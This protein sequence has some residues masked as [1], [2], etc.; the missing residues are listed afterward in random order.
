MIG[1]V[2]TTRHD[3]VAFIADALTEENTAPAFIELFRANANEVAKGYSDSPSDIKFFIEKLVSD[4]VDA[5]GK[6]IKKVATL[7]KQREGFVLEMAGASSFI[8]G[9]RNN[10]EKVGLWLNVSNYVSQC[11]LFTMTTRYMF[12][13]KDTILNNVDMGL[14]YLRKTERFN[15]SLEAMLRWY[16]A[17]TPALTATGE[18]IIKN[19]TNFTYRVAIE[20][21]F[22][23]SN[24]ISLNLSIGKNFDTPFLTTTSFFSILGF[25]YSLFNKE[26]VVLN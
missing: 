18:H 22:I 11:D 13:K 4:R 19:E 15:V 24:D 6:L 1:S 25:N 7:I 16:L 10:V 21:S 8:T 20:S 5:N 9:N 2:I 12:K 17:K 26:R 14:S 3:A 23:I